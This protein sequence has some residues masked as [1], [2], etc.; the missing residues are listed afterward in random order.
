MRERFLAHLRAEKG[1]SPHT[2][3]AY[4]T[5]L[6]DLDGHLDERGH[7]LIGAEVRDLRGFLFQAGTGRSA[8]TVARHTAAIRTFYDWAAREGLVPDGRAGL[9]QP[10]KVGQRAPFVA[11]E[12]EADRLFEQPA[13]G[14]NGLRDRA[15]LETLYGA[16]LRV[17][18]ASALDRGDLDLGRGV[19]RVRR[20]KGGKDRHVPLGP[21]AVDA[22]RD[23]LAATPTGGPAVFLNRSGQR[24]GVRSMH[25]IVHER[26]LRADV[27]GL[28]PHALR[29]SFA[30]HLLDA[31]ADLRGIQALLGHENLSTTQRYT[32][33]SVESLV[34][35]YRKAHPH[36]DDDGSDA[37]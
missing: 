23:W 24:L 9:L 16:G 32:K 6:R 14:R 34:A 18:E 20:G 15:L 37:G 11:T 8:A 26:G 29:H 5:T 2:L 21:P 13:T 17:A 7:C 30:T 4:A 36:A 31:G 27:P 25:R 3:R 33:V 35:T 10:P 1:A 22:L 19:V 28:H 12:E